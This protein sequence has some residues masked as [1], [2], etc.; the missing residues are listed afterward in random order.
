MSTASKYPAWVDDGSTISDPLGYGERAVTFLRRL[1]HP[2]AVNTNCAPKAV[3]ANRHPRALQLAPFQERIVRR[4]YGPRHEDGRRIVK[5]VFLMLPR[6]NRKTSLAAALSLLHVIGP[7]KVPAGQV[8]FAASDREQAGIGFREAADIIRQDK[9]LVAATRIHDAF[10]SAKQI[11]HLDSSA[12]LRA[13]S[14]DGRAQHGT[15]P[16]FVLADEI[17]AWKGRDLWEALK[18]GLAK[19]DDSLLVVATTAGRGH[20]TLAAEQYNYARRVALGEIDNPDFLPIIFAAEPD[21]DWQAEDVWHRVNPGLKH[22]FP[23]LSGLRS[24]AKEAED[25][26]AERYSFQQYNLN[27]WHGNSRDPLFSITTY[28]ARCFDDDETDLETLQCWVGVDMAKNGD[29]AAVVAAWRHPDGQVTVKPWFFVPGDEL[30]ERAE[31]DGVPYE[32]WRDDGLINATPGPIINPEA[33]E[34]H[35]RE[36]AARHDV[37]E[38]AFDPHLAR[39]TMQ[40]LYD[41]GLPVIEHRQAPLSMGVAIGD[42]ERTVNGQLIRHDGH[43]VLRHHFDSVVASRNETT[44]LVRMHKGKKTDRIDGA[45]AAAMAV[46]RAV[47]GESNKSQYTGDDAEIFTF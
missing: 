7:E 41:D 5:T 37:Q 6:G 29:T 25:H 19:T 14:S 18:S 8:I 3:N 22:G 12:R 43:P 45:V 40:R 23:S 16:A 2:A 44:G 26:P 33:V 21:D 31:Q 24:L 47:A 30:R 46:H 1:R 13:V 35:I 27:I 42:L 17:H 10:N 38:I 39:Q 34:D 4:I 36:L 9:R 15:T 20:E 11:T 32:R 28:D